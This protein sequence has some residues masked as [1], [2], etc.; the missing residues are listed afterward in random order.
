VCVCV[1]ESNNPHSLE[2]I[3]NS[4]TIVDCIFSIFVVVVVVVAQVLLASNVFVVA[5]ADTVF[6]SNKSKPECNLI[7][8]PRFIEATIRSEN[9]KSQER[10]VPLFHKRRVSLTRLYSRKENYLINP[11]AMIVKSNLSLLLFR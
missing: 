9:E 1:C 4:V 3:I 2:S 10:Q 11:V 6:A 5:V 7:K 8:K